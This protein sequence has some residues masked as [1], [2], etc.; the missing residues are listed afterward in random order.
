V[1]NEE[2][3]P[4]V[5]A[6]LDDQE[7]WYSDDPAEK[8]VSFQTK[9][10]AFVPVVVLLA[11]AVFYLP[12]TVGGKIT[13]S[14]DGG[15]EFG[16]SASE[17]VTCA[18]TPVNL[19]VTPTSDFAN[20]SNSGTLFL[21]SIRVTGISNAGC[22]GIDFK[23]RAYDKTSS[24]PLAIFDSTKTVAV[25]NVRTLNKYEPGAD[26][27]GTT[28]TPA[29]QGF[30]VTFDSPVALSTSV[31]K[32]TIETGPQYLVPQTFPCGSAGTFTVIN[33]VVRSS[34][35]N[36]AGSITVPSGVT[37][38]AASAFRDRTLLSGTVSLPDGLKTIES[39]AFRATGDFS[40]N[41]PSSVNNID[42]AF[43]ASGVTSVTF[44]SPSSLTSLGNNTFRSGGSGGRLRSI[45][46]PDEV[47]SFGDRV[48][49]DQSLPNSPFSSTSNIV[50]MGTNT[51]YLS[52][53][54]TSFVIPT[55]VKTLGATVFNPVRQLKRLTIPT[56]LNTI[57]L[58]ALTGIPAL[59]CVIYTGSNTNILNFY[60]P[61]T[62]T[63]TTVSTIR[64]T[65]IAN[66]PAL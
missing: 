64:Q 22:V 16:Q 53:S 36:C 37:S 65:N 2:I 61:E 30:T 24:T 19:R 45:T 28:V 9:I 18:G 56:G 1:A 10:R 54:F 52:P 49:G 33:T 13:L 51:F 48:F 38:I 7:A 3:D 40:I 27:V 35:S 63:V 39:S 15:I 26:S 50:N 46:I 55:G 34:S 14:S 32:L 6:E 66:C 20:D 8:K 44:D 57:E 42:E 43:Y 21:K 11:A 4:E 41:I 58:G 59:N 17:I 31:H 23:L 62:Q 29:T 12:T 25:V 5:D 47:T 60:F